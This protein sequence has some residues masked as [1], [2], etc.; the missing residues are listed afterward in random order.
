MS[1]EF[2]KQY[3]MF[4]LKVYFENISEQLGVEQLN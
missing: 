4:I 3:Q 1:Y 2:N